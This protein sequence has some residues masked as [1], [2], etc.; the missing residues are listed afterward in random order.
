M[1]AYLSNDLGRELWP[2]HFS[3]GLPDASIVRTSRTINQPMD[4]Q[5]NSGLI[6]EFQK[7]GLLNEAARVTLV[8]AV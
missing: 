3:G 2:G 6:S 5:K 8:N 1:L 4:A 7:K